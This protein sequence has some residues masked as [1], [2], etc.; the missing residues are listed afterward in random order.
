MIQSEVKKAT[1]RNN[2]TNNDATINVGK[3][4]N[5]LKVENS[6]KSTNNVKSDYKLNSNMKFELFVYYFLSELRASDIQHIIDENTK[7]VLRT[8]K[9]LSLHV[10]T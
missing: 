4:A 8:V 6:N 2:Q 10:V 3:G 9:T 7:V 5:T 1:T